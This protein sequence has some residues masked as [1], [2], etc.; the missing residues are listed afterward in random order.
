[1]PPLRLR[2]LP[3][4]VNA[5]LDGPPAEVAADKS[6]GGAVQPVWL[7]AR[8]PADAAPGD[9]RGTM[10]VSAEGMK[11]VEVPVSLVDA[12]LSGEGDTVNIRAAVAELQKKRGDIVTVTEP[13]TTVRV[14]IDNQN[15][16]D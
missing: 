15:V 8:V 1:M 9:Y 6:G 7:S 10:T 3:G 13:D 16:Q 14:W 2:A 5:M 11:G 4:N 12:L